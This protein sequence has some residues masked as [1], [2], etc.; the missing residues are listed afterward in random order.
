M[1]IR[2]NILFIFLFLILILFFLS[3]SSFAVEELPL[4]NQQYESINKIF[5]DNNYTFYFVNQHYEV[6]FIHCPTD[7][8]FYV[9]SGTLF[10]EKSSYTWYKYDLNS[11]KNTWSGSSSNGH[12]GFASLMMSNTNVYSDNTF[13]DFF[14]KPPIL[15][16]ELGGMKM[17]VLM[18]VVKILPLIIVVVVSF[19]GLR[20]AWKLLSM[21]LHQ[22]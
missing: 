3:N 10:C 21:L 9:R 22:A 2:K 15:M 18:E 12:G 1:N 14:F 4:S 16:M 5:N 17:E 8:R 13:S 20:K 6:Y 7:V 11:L 19:L